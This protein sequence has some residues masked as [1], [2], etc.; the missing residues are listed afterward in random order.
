MQLSLKDAR[1]IP[2]AVLND[3][4]QSI[5]W[6]TVSSSSQIL[7]IEG[8]IKIGKC[9]FNIFYFNL[10]FMNVHLIGENQTFCESRVFV[11]ETECI[12]TIF[13]EMKQ[14]GII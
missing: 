3:S 6:G 4:F 8:N 1:P 11:C 10:K 14:L 12:S 13:H 7:C 2:D 5:L 9:T